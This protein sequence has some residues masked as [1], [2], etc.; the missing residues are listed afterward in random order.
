MKPSK[1]KVKKIPRGLCAVCKKEITLDYKDAETLKKFT[2]ER[3]RILPRSRTR[4]CAK[5]QRHLSEQ[6]KRARFLGLLPFVV[7]A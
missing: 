2:S 7:K 5:H 6:L 4:L 3:G 1:K